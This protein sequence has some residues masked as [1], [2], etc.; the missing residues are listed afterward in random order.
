M[1]LKFKKLKIKGM[2]RSYFL[3][4]FFKTIF[5][6]IKKYYFS[7][8]LKMLLFSGKKKK[9]KPN[10]LLLFSLFFLFFKNRK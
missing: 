10:L 6:N 5:E 1:I 7:V 2:F 4:M 8:L 9:K 3:K